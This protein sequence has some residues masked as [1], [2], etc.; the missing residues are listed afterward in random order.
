MLGSPVGAMGVIMLAGV[1]SSFARAPQNTGGGDGGGGIVHSS[2]EPNRRAYPTYGTIVQR[3]VFSRDPYLRS[4]AA[5][6]GNEIGL[7]GSEC[8]GYIHAAAPDLD[9]NNAAGDYQLAIYA[10]SDTDITLIVNGA[11][12][13]WYCS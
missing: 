12:G 11:D 8:T 6:G 3:A 9:L 7:G 13:R 10:K 5:G 1:M 4:I 2:G